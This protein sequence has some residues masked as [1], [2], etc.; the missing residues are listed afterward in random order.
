MLITSK[1]LYDTVYAIAYRIKLDK[2]D[3]V[4]NGTKGHFKVIKSTWR[5]WYADPFLYEKDNQIWLFVEK[6]DRIKRKGVLAVSKYEN[7]C[8]GNFEDILEE[9]FHLSYPMIFE[10]SGKI[11]MIPE[12]VDNKSLILYEAVSFPFQWKKRH[13]LKKNINFV[14]SNIFKFENTWYLLTCEMDPKIGSYTKLCLYNAD[15]IETGELLSI[16]EFNKFSAYSFESRG[17][18]QIFEEENILYR[19]VQCGDKKNYGKYL[20]LEALTIVDGMLKRS[21]V[22]EMHYEDFKYTSSVNIQGMHT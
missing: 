19:P 13:V 4:I 10:K 16:N 3:S 22:K 17:G 18:G 7:G 2:K 6:M 1:L 15:K 21:T 8:W 11:Y 14:D 5:Y 9:S 12:S 20:R